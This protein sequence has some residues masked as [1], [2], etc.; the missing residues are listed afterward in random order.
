MTICGYSLRIGASLSFS[1]KCASISPTSFASSLASAMRDGAIQRFSIGVGTI[2]SA[3]VQLL[4][5][6]ASYTLLATCPISRNDIV[7]LAW[8]SRSTRSVRLPRSASAAARLMAVVVLPT[9]PF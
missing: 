1:R 8:G 9:P 5:A 2:T 7:L 3:S 6:T 4:S